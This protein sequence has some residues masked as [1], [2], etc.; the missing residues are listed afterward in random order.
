MGYRS[1]F[2]T[3]SAG[4]LAV[5]LIIRL[6]GQ[7]QFLFGPVGKAGTALSVP[8]LVAGFLYYLLRPVVEWL[9][10]VKIPKTAAIL[11]VYLLMLGLLTGAGIYGGIMAGRQL[12]QLTADLPDI[13]AAM[14]DWGG[15]WIQM[16]RPG[17]VFSGKIGQQ[18]GQ[19]VQKVV[20]FLIEG[21]LAAGAALA[22][23]APLLMLVP[24][25]LF[26][27]LRDDA[28]FAG[29]LLRR[30]PGKHRKTAEVTLDSLDGVLAAYITGQALLATGQAILMYAG[31][32]IVGLP[33]ALILAGVV[34]ITSFIPVFGLILGSIPAL[35]VG[36]VSSPGMAV[37]ILIWL[38]L[39]NLLRKL[40]APQWVGKK[41]RIHP[42]L[43]I[44]I[45]LVAGA[46]WGFG[47]V[48]VGVPVYA[49]V[50][51]AVKG[52]TGVKDH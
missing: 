23:A 21:I 48:M 49:V 4:I 15:Q 14:G 29:A 20:P 44:G 41:L 18:A 37:K 26:Y 8:M 27:L 33:Y 47:G 19:V 43:M 7:L 22:K 30:I 1:N 31:F 40:V 9:E 38:V 36:V 39:V 12:G 24:L 42:L 16:S 3:Y 45:S 6:A 11:L 10:Q 50:R 28:R 13:L 2:F 52:V 46:V 34:L 17:A 5:L 51:E 32:L 25:I 35:A